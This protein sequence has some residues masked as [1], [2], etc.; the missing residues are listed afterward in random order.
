M[1]I[2][3]NGNVLNLYSIEEECIDSLFKDQMKMIRGPIVR[4][5]KLIRFQLISNGI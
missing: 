3:L 2:K 4:V 5:W 1:S